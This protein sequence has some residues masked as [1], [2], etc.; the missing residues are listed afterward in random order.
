MKNDSS[1][2]PTSSTHAH[3]PPVLRTNGVQEQKTDV[4]ASGNGNV[5]TAHFAMLLLLQKKNHLSLSL[6]LAQRTAKETTHIKNCR[7]RENN[8]ERARR[9]GKRKRKRKI[10]TPKVVR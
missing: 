2:K 9:E 4:P 7:K 1:T 5:I 6:T 8:T 3:T 10:Q